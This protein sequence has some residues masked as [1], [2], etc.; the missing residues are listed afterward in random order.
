MKYLFI[1]ATFFIAA[2]VNAQSDLAAVDSFDAPWNAIATDGLCAPVTPFQFYAK[3][4]QNG[5]SH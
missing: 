3:P 4:A 1:V 2:G 5:S